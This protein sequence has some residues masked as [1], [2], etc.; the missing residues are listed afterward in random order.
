MIVTG[1]TY[2]QEPQYDGVNHPANEL[3]CWILT[4]LPIPAM[5][6]L[7]PLHENLCIDMPLSQQNS[8]TI[9]LL[10]LY[11]DDLPPGGQ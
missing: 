1:E 5:T 6:V 11:H 9:M 4:D 3:G 7:D 2:T 8:T 10:T